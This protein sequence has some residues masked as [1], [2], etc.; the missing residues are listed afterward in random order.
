MDKPTYSLCEVV[1]DLMWN[2]A[3]DLESGK[4]API[5]D[6]REVV[7]RVIEWAEEFEAK[8]AG[9]EWD[10]EYVEEIDAFYAEKTKNL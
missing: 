1:A 8:N 6:S 2:L 7:R 3:T 10:G 5:P 4:V 9:R